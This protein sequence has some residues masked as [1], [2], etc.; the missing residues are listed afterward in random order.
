MVIILRQQACLHTIAAPISLNTRMTS[1]ADI[2]INNL[3]P[4][5]NKRPEYIGVEIIDAPSVDVVANLP[6]YPLRITA[7]TS[8]DHRIVSSIWIILR[9]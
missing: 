2:V 8:S 3:G 7:P 1:V 9:H 4:D 6:Q 5:N